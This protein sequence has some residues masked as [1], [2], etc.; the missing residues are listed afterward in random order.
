MLTGMYTAVSAML[1]LQTSQTVIT[2]NMAN[3]N[4]TGFKAEK[5]IYKTFDDVLVQNNDNHV[6]GKGTN[7]QLG[8]LNPGVKIDE[9]K[10]NYE[11]GNI[12]ETGNKT[13]F[14]INGKGFFTV[15]DEE[16]NIF[17]TRNGA[18]NVNQQGYL[19]TSSGA[20]VLNSNNEPIYIGASNIT[21]DN[22]NNLIL[23]S[24]VVHR[25]NIVDFD[26]Y[27]GLEKV[28]EN[29]Y[30]GQGARAT[31][32]YKVQ[33][34][35]KESSNVD[36]IQS[37]ADLMANLRAFEANQKVVQVMDSILGKMA[38]EIGTVR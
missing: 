27:D 15:R 23:S 17:Y 21:V 20:Q 22:N 4:T 7:Q 38:S 28:G 31:N 19:V 36:I 32:E 5:V 29:L 35:A 24:G 18:F 25:F 12:I 34:M 30:T 16:G 6:N 1:D 8:I 13:D 3:V 33:N 10:T 9:I 37:T 14:A 26:N 2:N 11:Q